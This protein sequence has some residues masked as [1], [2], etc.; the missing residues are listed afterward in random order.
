MKIN[1]IAIWA[2]D[3]EQLRSFY[4]QYFGGTSGPRYHNPVKGFTSYFIT[5]EGDS[6]LELMHVDGLPAPGAPT[7]GLA[8]LSFSVGSQAAVDRLTEKLHQDGFKVLSQPRT[9]GDG[10]YESVIADPEDNI[11]EITI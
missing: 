4:T 5:F 2:K 1:H 3:L 9:T 10:Y 6:R 8:H 11:V 7:M